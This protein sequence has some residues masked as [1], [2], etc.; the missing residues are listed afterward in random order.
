M[1]GQATDKSKNK[2]TYEFQT[3][4]VIR[5]CFKE[6]FGIPRQPGLVPEARAILELHPP[7]NRPE[8]IAE[9][10]GFSHIWVIFIFHE[11][12]LQVGMFGCF[13]KGKI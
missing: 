8:A 10:E 1:P 4:G 11:K 6:K 5:S 13:P 12:L 3:I 9:L 2:H 7:Y